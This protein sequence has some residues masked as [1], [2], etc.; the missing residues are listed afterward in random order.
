MKRYRVVHWVPGPELGMDAPWVASED[1]MHFDAEAHKVDGGALHL[2]VGGEVVTTFAP[3]HWV[4]VTIEEPE[5][6]S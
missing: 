2:L 1:E 5:P 6:V 3:G 4:V